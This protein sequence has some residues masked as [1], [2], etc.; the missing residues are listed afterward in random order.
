MSLPSYNPKGKKLTFEQHLQKKREHEEQQA[1]LKKE[2]QGELPGRCPE[3]GKGK[4][5]LRCEPGLL[6]RTCKNPNCLHEKVF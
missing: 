4:F 3:C 5:T 1:Q 2:N 6:I